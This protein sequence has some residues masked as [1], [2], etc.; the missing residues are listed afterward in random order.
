MRTLATVAAA[1]VV[2]TRLWAAEPAKAEARPTATAEVKDASGKKLGD[3]TLE[4]AAHGLIVK[5]TLKGLPPGVHALHI[6][7]VGKCEG[8]AF[9]SAGGHFNPGSK[10]HGIKNAK[11]MHAGDLPNIDVPADGEAQLEAFAHGLTISDG[12]MSIFDKDG[13]A[14]V[15]H[16]SADDYSTNPAGNAGD[17]IACGVIERS[18]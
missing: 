7:E 3:V 10:E 18:K 12:P 8:P 14:I 16:A 9:K 4:Q 11:G 5:A 2:T 13:S 15:I 1:L 17:R 6:H